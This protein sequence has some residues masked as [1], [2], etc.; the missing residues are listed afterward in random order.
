MSQYVADILALYV[1]LPEHVRELNQLP[2]G[3]A[4]RKIDALRGGPD[5]PAS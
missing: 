4:T 1:G 5:E 3:G 2:I